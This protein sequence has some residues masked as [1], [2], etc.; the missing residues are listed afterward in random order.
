MIS[1]K[2]TDSVSELEAIIKL[3]KNNLPKN[4]SDSEKKA[5]GFVTVQH[6][7][8]LLKKMQN[9]YP[10]IIAKHNNTVIG[11][12]LCMFYKIKCRG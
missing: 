3:Q 12:A 7:L 9:S 8:E 2:T 1:Y 11:Y 6:T 4:I 10:H 5:Q